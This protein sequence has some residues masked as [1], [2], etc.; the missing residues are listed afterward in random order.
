MRI[1]QYI[2]GSRRRK[3]GLLVAKKNEKGAVVIGWSL[4]RSNMDRWDRDEAFRLAENRIEGVEPLIPV[5]CTVAKDLTKFMERCQS[6]FRAEADS[7]R[8]SG[9]I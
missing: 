3:I 5:P 1:F 7:V 2:R 4:C 8:I 9:G 6:Y